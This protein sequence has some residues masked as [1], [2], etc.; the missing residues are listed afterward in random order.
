[1]DILN[2]VILGATDDYVSFLQSIPQVADAPVAFLT[3]FLLTLM[4]FAPIVA[5]VPFL[6]SKMPGPAKAGFLVC[7][8][9]FFIPHIA[10]TTTTPLAF[11]LAFIAYALKELLVG[12]IIAFLASVPFY[13]ATSA[14]VLIDFLRGSSALQVGDPT[15]QNQSSSIGVFYNQVLIVVF[16]QLG[17]PF[18]FFDAMLTSYKIIPIDKM[19][20]V[21]FFN[22]SLPFWQ[23]IIQLL[24]KVTALSIQFAAPSILAI[25]MAE[26]F[27]GIANRLAPNV[28]I[29]FLGMA[30][31]SIFGL[32]LL[33]AGWFFIL[34]QMGKFSLSWFHEFVSALSSF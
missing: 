25:L 15:M 14:G 12:F 2:R 7:L 19:I 5:L 22:S 3:A 31:K 10:L 4:R 20:P 6:G 8:A 11:N 33:W 28:Q 34:Q 16:F 9:A 13:I 26:M 18:F 21:H 29:A 24:T 32:G 23:L 30:L 27:L 1:M 17:G